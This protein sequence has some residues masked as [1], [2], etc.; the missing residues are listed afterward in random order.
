MSMCASFRCMQ[1]SFIL[2]GEHHT[3]NQVCGL[4][5][6]IKSSQAFTKPLARRPV[7]ALS[8]ECSRFYSCSRIYAN[9]AS[10]V[11]SQLISLRYIPGSVPFAD[12]SRVW[13]DFFVRVT[14]R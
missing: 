7:R 13:M 3:K 8:S 5:D 2:A 9:N 4:D 10:S 12:T 11:T 6:L 14:V 1:H